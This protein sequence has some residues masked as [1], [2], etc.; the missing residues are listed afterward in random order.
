MII[1]DMVRDIDIKDCCFG[2]THVVK[3]KARSNSMVVVW[4]CSVCGHSAITTF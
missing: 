4:R 1:K 2:N 3:V